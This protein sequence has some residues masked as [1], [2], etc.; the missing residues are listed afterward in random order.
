M[1]IKRRDFLKNSFGG[2]LALSLRSAALGLPASFLMNQSVSAA[3]ASAK[4]T[5]ISVSERGESINANGPG[6]YGEGV[7][8]Q[9]VHPNANEVGSVTATINGTQ[10][11]AMDLQMGADVTFG[12]QT[13]KTARA[14]Q[15]LDSSFRDNLAF[16]MHRTGTNAHPEIK[17]VI[18]A[19]GAIKNAEG[20]GVEQL[21]S[22]IAQEM[23]PLLKTSMTKPI[24]LDG[25]Y[26]FNGSPLG[27]FRPTTLREIILSGTN[28]GVRPEN[29]TAVYDWTLNELYK[30]VKREGSPRQKQFLD[31]HLLSREQAAQLGDQLGE[32]LVNID[33][34]D[35]ESQLRA[36]LAL[37]KIKFCPVVVV[38]HNFGGDNHDDA[39]LRSETEQTF[40]ALNALDTYRKTLN[41]YGLNNDVL[42]ATVDVFGRTP[43]RNHK[44]G[45]D[46]YG[47]F[48]TA[49]I[50][51]SNVNG[52]TI[53]D[54]SEDRHRNTKFLAA[55]GI[56]SQTGRADNPDIRSDET[57]AA[58][59]KSIM[60]AT[61]VPEYRRDI[62]IP[63]G[64]VVQSLCG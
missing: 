20:R 9:V 36:A 21:P 5:I 45:R 44:G 32:L 28:T 64:K 6:T 35:G 38:R 30:N 16:F 4:Y 1:S 33:S 46:H 52:G 59:A 63:D 61:G 22:A 40:N 53:G 3:D 49:M 13:V 12:K 14:Y 2:G 56:N 57:L 58:L 8:S 29:F 7:A 62:R 48:T 15:A 27:T 11:N 10:V 26:S 51:G 43:T 24:V 47:N 18:A 60:A 19:N 50:H 55:S 23:A 25:N 34:N 42:Y 17:S 39:Q 54:L 37:V 31:N 41:E